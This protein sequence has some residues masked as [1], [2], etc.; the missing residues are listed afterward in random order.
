MSG[1]WEKGGAYLYAPNM[2]SFVYYLVTLKSL[3]VMPMNCGCLSGHKREAVA[4]L[5]RERLTAG[6]RK[7][8]WFYV[9]NV[10][11]KENIP[12][13]LTDCLSVLKGQSWCELLFS[14][15]L[16]LSPSR[17]CFYRLQL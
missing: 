16:F 15:S 9:K 11:E 8:A 7:R 6:E 3:F 1:M 2:V 4:C 17:V 14:P 13:G 12:W 5:E 10:M